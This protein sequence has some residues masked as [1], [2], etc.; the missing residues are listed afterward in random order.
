MPKVNKQ[1]QNKPWYKNSNNWAWIVI[2]I[3]FLTFL[4]IIF[5]DDTATKPQRGYHNMYP[6]SY[7]YEPRNDGPG[8]WKPDPNA[9]QRV[10]E[11]IESGG[12][13]DPHLDAL[14]DSDFYDAIDQLG[15]E[16]GF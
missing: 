12:N 13:A 10:R 1:P 6:D 8:D 3:C 14:Q 7:D 9:A 5:T 4:I 2:G 16:E 11:F 15:G